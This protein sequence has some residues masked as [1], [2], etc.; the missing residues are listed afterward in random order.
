MRIIVRVVSKLGKGKRRR[1]D[2]RNPVRL[3]ALES[4]TLMSGTPHSAGAHRAAVAGVTAA[5]GLNVSMFATNPAGASQPDSIAVDGSSVF[6]GYG[7]GV[8]KDG[9]DGLSSTIVQYT[10]AGAIVRSFSVPGHNDGLK[11]D[12]STHLVWALQNE[13]GNP[14]LVVID[15]VAA[16]QKN[17][18]FAAPPADGGGYDDIVFLD[19]KVF[20]SESNPAS[21][22]N[23]APAVVQATLG[24]STVTVTPVLLGNAAA[25]NLV[26]HH[27]VTLNLQDPDSMTAT[28]SGSLL[29]TSQADDELVT[30]KHPGAAN[31]SVTV[32]PLSDAKHT[33]VSVDDTLFKP[34]P[35]GSILLTDLSGGTIYRIT[36]SAV[37]PG[38]TLSAA[39]D[40]GEVGKLNLKTGRFTPVITGLESPRGLAFL[41]DAKNSK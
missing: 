14:N 30:I 15:P 16:T 5:H 12:P 37:K 17:Y 25:T 10:S 9:S 4:R 19:G 2:R 38:L 41:P 26:T 1:Q 35:K 31:Q 6:V 27:H 39:Q 24:A 36:G 11:V 28:P 18:T 20:L 7:D 3:E 22:P 8:A 29:L 21:N 40:I 34:G 32:L 33:A 23:T 13:D